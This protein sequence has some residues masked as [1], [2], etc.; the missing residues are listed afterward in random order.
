MKSVAPSQYCHCL[1][2][3]WSLC[4]TAIDRVCASCNGNG[5]CRVDSGYRYGIRR[6]HRAQCHISPIGKGE[7]VRSCIRSGK[8]QCV[9]LKV[10]DTRQW[11]ASHLLSRSCFLMKSAAPLRN[12]HCSLSAGTCVRPVLILYSPPV[13]DDCRCIDACYCIVFDV[14]TVLSAN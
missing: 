3:R 9:I 11:S 6:Y 12:C 14:I 2:C 8:W 5:G 10:S 7:R 1:L 4:M 13:I